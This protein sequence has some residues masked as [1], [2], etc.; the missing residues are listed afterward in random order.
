L[1]TASTEVAIVSGI[2]PIGSWVELIVR[3]E[4]LVSIMLVIP[5]SWQHVSM[6]AIGDHVVTCTSTSIAALVLLTS[7][8]Q[9]CCVLLLL[10]I[11]FQEQS[12]T[13]MVAKACAK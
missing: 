11:P 7:S 8:K 6:S 2:S 9:P 1:L 3:D 4:V 13:V 10:L 5:F 12:A